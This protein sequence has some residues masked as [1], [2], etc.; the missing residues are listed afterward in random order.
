MNDRMNA[1][2]TKMPQCEA[3][4]IKTEVNRFYFLGFD[5]GD[6]GTVLLLRDKAYFIIDSRYIEIATENVKSA[7][8]VLENK[9]LVQVKEL[10]EK[11]GV[12][13]LHLESGLTLGEAAKLSEALGGGIEL[14]TSDA[15]TGVIT[16]LRA[17]KSEEEVNAIRRAQ[18]ITDDCFSYM[19]TYI[20]PGMREID[21]ALEMEMFMRR[22]GAKKLA[23]NTILIAGKKTSLPH[24]E[25]GNNI[26]QNGDFITMDFGANVDGYCSDMTRT[27][28]LGSITEEQRLVYETVLKAQLAACEGAK[29]GMRGCEVDKISRD[30]INSAGFEGKFGHGL[31]HSLGIEIHE[32]PR[33][34]PTCDTIIQKG[35]M[36]TIEP[37]IYLA[38]KFGV[39]I[40]DTVLMCENGI[41]ILAKSDKNLIVI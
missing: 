6:A 10:L 22:A 4:Y 13:K 11:H 35:M 40:E 2:F 21:I 16:N 8:V 17:I 32:D 15:L 41:E 12:K 36:M 27:I 31:G 7:E 25:P 24:G 1:L 38:G 5:S 37:G 28:A 26:V 19:L 29:A 30:I 14:D 23:F 3:A 9:A 18:K 39:R 20:K 33:F 34:S